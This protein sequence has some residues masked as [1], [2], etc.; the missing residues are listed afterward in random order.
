MLMHRNLHILIRDPGDNHNEIKR[1]KHVDIVERLD[2][3]RRNA[4]RSETIYRIRL[5]GLNETH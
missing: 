1:R 3:S 2:M 4:S 5:R